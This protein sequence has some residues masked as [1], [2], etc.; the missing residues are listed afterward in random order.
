[1]LHWFEHLLTSV[2][3]LVVHILIGLVVML[4]SMGIP[5]PGETILVA[6]ALLAGTH[7]LHASP[8]GIAF[9]GAAGAIIGDSIGY[10]VVREY[11]DRLLRWLHRR[12]PKQVAPLEL[13]WAQHIFKR[14]GFLAVFFGRFVALLRMF[15]GP[16][17]GLMRMHYY[18][19][20][21]ANALG[22]IAWSCLFTYVIYYAG[23]AADSTL[24]GASWIALAVVVVLAVVF[25][26]VM[27]RQMGRILDRFKQEHPDEVSEAEERLGATA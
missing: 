25:S 24:K 12:F 4:E 23:E 8:H 16:L 15:A 17:S 26:L 9:S 3:P 27:K 19:F 1:M 20:F 6:A 10:W 14:Y 13:A 7:S 22:G 2:N 5:L 18:K 11:G 21:A